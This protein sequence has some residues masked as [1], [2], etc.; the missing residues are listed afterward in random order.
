M[1]FQSL[2]RKHFLG[3]VLLILTAAPAVHAAVSFDVSMGMNVNEDTR[4][5]LNV[6]NEVWRPAMPVTV[7][8]RMRYPEDDFPVIA[9]LAFHTHRDPGAILSLRNEGYPWNEV[10]FR[11]NVSPSVLFVGMDRDPGPPYGNAWGYWKKNSRPGTYRR[12]RFADRDVVGLVKVQTAARHFGA[13]PFAVIDAQR[14]GKRV[15]AYTANRWREKHGR[16]TWAANRRGADSRD[17]ARGSSDS[18]QMRGGSD[19]RETR[20]GTKGKGKGNK[21]EG[22]GQGKGHGQGNGH[23]R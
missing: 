5:F 15:E 6:S 22:Q 19:S 9:F 20:G 10:F 11:L 18:R 7:I 1:D 23:G 13:S 8:E 4:I 2:G 16:Q 21:G 14:Q 17:G 3:A 12:V